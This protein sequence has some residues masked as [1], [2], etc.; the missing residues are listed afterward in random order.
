MSLAGGHHMTKHAHA[1]SLQQ[2]FRHFLQP[3]CFVNNKQEKENFEI[4]ADLL[5]GKDPNG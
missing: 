5:A 2:G 1:F 4:S 3:L